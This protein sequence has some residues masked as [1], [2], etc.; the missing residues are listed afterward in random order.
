M[1]T[2]SKF[3]WETELNPEQ[4]EAV[5]HGDG[6]QLVIAGAGSG[7]TRVITYRVAWMIHEQGVDPRSVAAVTFTNKAAGE[8]RERIEKLLGVSRLDSFVGTFHRLSLDLLRKYGER[9]GVPRNLTIFDTDDQKKLV[10]KA[11]EEEKLDPTRFPP[12]GMLSAI[13]DAKNRMLSIEQFAAE[14]EGFFQERVA[15]VYRRYQKLLE[16]SGGV[17][18][19][20]MLLKAVKLMSTQDDLKAQLR[21]R[22]RYLMV[23]EFQDT[24]KVQLR[25]VHEL[26]GKAGNLTAVGDEDQGIYRWRGAD[27]DNILEFERW[28]PGATIRK[29]ERNYRSTGNILAAAGAVVAHNRQRRGKTLWTE[30]DPGELLELYRAG[31]EQDEA[32]WV[33]NT[34]QQMQDDVLLSDMAILVRTNAQTRALEERLIRAKVPY[35]L[36]AGVRFYERAEVKD[37]VAYLRVLRNPDDDVSMGRILNTPPRGIGKTTQDAIAA[38][39]SENGTSLWGAITGEA[40]LPVAARS[41]TAVN[42]FRDLILELQQLLDEPP[43]EIINQVLERSGYAEFLRGKG[44]E[45]ESRLENLQEFASAAKQFEEDHP[46]IEDLLEAFLDHAALVSDI[47]GWHPEKGIS[48]MTLHAAKGLEFQVVFVA[49]LEDGV[50]P[51][52]N[53]GDAEEDLE[54]ERRLFYVGMTRARGRLFLTTCRRRRI[55]GR[56]QD[57]LPSPFLEEVPEKYLTAHRSPELFGVRSQ[58]A[59]SFF[60]GAPSAARHQQRVQKAA[61]SLGKS[62][63]GRGRKVRHAS[64]GEGVILDV[65]GS[66]EDSKLTIYFQQAG[67]KKLVAKYADLEW[68]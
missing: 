43:A 58:A 56:Y 9:I 4:Y 2:T 10:K 16:Q 5:T 60:R 18:F 26:V 20:D 29:L 52:F 40:L 62:A 13:S 33:V 27:L 61:T 34:V 41:Q 42:R 39:A 3:P 31:D 65:E 46:D 32:R 38:L 63:R 48:L 66:G 57:Q 17:D 8:M 53:A 28:F 1:V 59:H 35:T 11:I 68:L 37:A 15:R 6:P 36:V 23:D 21:Q 44:E 47:D 24:N 49:G 25:L 67:R 30:D 7:K 55:A 54:E 14:S 64:L 51:H 12:R 45:A 50:L 19:D 22:V